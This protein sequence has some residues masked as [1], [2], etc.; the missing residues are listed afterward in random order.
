M[1]TE[2]FIE[3]SKQIHG[4][5]YDYSLTNYTDYKTPVT[6]LCKI[7]STF[8]QTPTSH[9]C[10]KRGCQTCAN[11]GNGYQRRKTK[12]LFIIDAQYKFGNSFDYSKVI[13]NTQKDEVI[14]ICNK[15]NKE[16][17]Q[18][19]VNHLSGGGWCLLCFELQ[20]GVSQKSNTEDFIV[21]SKQ[22]HGDLYD[23]SKVEYV[24]SN[25]F[26]K[27]VCNIHNEYLQRPTDHIKGHGC[28][29]CCYENNRVI[30]KSD[31]QTFI[32]KARQIHGN[33]YNY[34]DVI[35]MSYKEKVKIFCNK[36]G[37][38]LQK[39]IEHLQGHGCQECGKEKI[40]NVMPRFCP[41]IN[42]FTN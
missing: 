34:S 39:P 21:K 3:K 36:H 16:F 27:I 22:I 38:F 31:S 23:Y 1:N 11:I 28:K 37:I 10:K 20:R 12:E 17:K 30:G 29:Y 35:Y 7:H 33:K 6:I 19:P 24:N 2:K 40:W 25:T 41:T 26:V 8:F 5:K 4:D 15:C 32:E 42:N 14:I 9:L 18:K 13:Y